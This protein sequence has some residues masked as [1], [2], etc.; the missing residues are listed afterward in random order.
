MPETPKTPL[1]NTDPNIVTLTKLTN[2]GG[3]VLNAAYASQ[4]AYLI[5]SERRH[6]K[7]PREKLVADHEQEKQKLLSKLGVTMGDVQVVHRDPCCAIIVKTPDTDI[8][9]FTGTDQAKD[10]K[11]NLNPLPALT[12]DHK[13]NDGKVTS[14]IVHGGFQ[15]ALS[16]SS[17]VVPADTLRKEGGGYVATVT[18]QAV[19]MSFA[20]EVYQLATANSVNGPR[21]MLVTGHSLGS[22]LAT[23]ATHDYIHKPDRNKDNLELIAFSGPVVGPGITHDLNQLMPGKV[24]NFA[25]P[26]DIVNKIAAST[27]PGVSTVLD[28]KGGMKSEWRKAELIAAG[29]EN[30]LDLQ[31]M[32]PRAVRNTIDNTATM[33]MGMWNTNIILEYHDMKALTGKLETQ[34]GKANGLMRLPPIEQEEPAIQAQRIPSAAPP[35]K[36]PVQPAGGYQKPGFLR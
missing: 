30:P 3:D 35:M 19:K 11:I 31:G 13:A 15:R 36:N 21:K 16:R 7:D 22:A 23:L 26:K 29:K 2:Q 20:D 27:S 32:V 34:V 1:E 5:E 14:R 8:I 25:H 12:P 9:A 33:F 10:W 17:D 6:A 18:D 24:F 28:D 4:L